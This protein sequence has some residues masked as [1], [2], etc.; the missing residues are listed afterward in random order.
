M[1]GRLAA[2]RAG[3][4]AIF[5]PHSWAF[6]VDY[7]G[8]RPLLTLAI[9]RGLGPLSAGV[10]CVSEHE[11]QVA[12]RRRIVSPERLYVVHNGCAACDESV[13]PM[14][15]L[16]ELRAGGPLAAAVTGL[17]PQKSVDVLIEAA[18]LVWQRLPE[19]RIAV[20]GNG[21]DRERLQAVA[22]EVGI[23]GDPRFAMLPFTAPAARALRAIDV[24]VLPSAYEGFPIA[25]LEAQACGVPQVVTNVG[26][27]PEAVT[28]QTGIVVPPRDPPAMATAIA[29]LL[30]DP[31]RRAAM[32]AASRRRQAER[33][34]LEHMVAGVAEV[35]RRVL[36]HGSTRLS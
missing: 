15:E 31:D 2:W 25:P 29:D 24:Y 1:L 13:E 8:G 12:L 20:V 23:E 26:G 4:P 21:P 7:G 5:S 16:L 10:L 22:R 18:P 17:R 27:T 33:F 28:A 32:S 9:E 14:P 11:R 6:D 35:Y 3:V 36:R 19:A 30:A 34:T